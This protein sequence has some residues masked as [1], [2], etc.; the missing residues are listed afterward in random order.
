MFYTLLLQK[1]LEKAR[2]F[3]TFFYLIRLKNF[4][5]ILFDKMLHF[6]VNR[7]YLKENECVAKSKLEF[8]LFNFLPEFGL[9][10]TF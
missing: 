10:R 9:I 3:S 7:A 5:P 1:T 4:L 2:P 8:K 6:L